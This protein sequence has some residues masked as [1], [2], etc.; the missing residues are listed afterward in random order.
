MLYPESPI[1]PHRAPKRQNYYFDLTEM[2]AKLI[3]VSEGSVV[4]T[5]LPNSC[6]G[7]VGRRPLAISLFRDCLRGWELPRSSTPPH[8]VLSNDR[9]MQSYTGPGISA[10]WGGNLMGWFSSR[11]LSSGCEPIIAG[12]LKLL[13]SSSPS[14][15]SSSSFSC[16]GWNL[17]AH[18]NN[19]SA[20]PQTPSQHPLLQNLVHG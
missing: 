6:W 4:Q 2:G 16:T 20:T 19:H 8:A 17:R 5:T 7:A 15:S 11:A 1:Q 12:L 9:W 18:P 3:W 13:K 10:A 14:S